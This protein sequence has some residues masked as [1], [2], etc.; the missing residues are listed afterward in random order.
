[1]IDQQ[2]NNQEDMNK[3]LEESC[4]KIKKYNMKKQ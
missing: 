4:L 2:M 1:M 3:S